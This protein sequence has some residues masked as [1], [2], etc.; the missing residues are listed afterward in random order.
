MR[1]LRNDLHPRGITVAL[2]A[3]G[4]VET[5]MLAESGYHGKALSPADSAAGLYKMV[6]ALTPDDPGLP[7]NVDGKTMPW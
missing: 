4:M 2:V 1:A 3:P 5:D 7:V 6:A